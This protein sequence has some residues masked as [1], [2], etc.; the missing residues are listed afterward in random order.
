MRNIRKLA[1]WCVKRFGRTFGLDI[2]RVARR[3]APEAPHVLASSLVAPYAENTESGPANLELKL[4]RAARGGPF[5]CSDIVCT[6]QT[7]ARMVGS[8]R[9]IAELGGG[10]GLFAYEVATDP[11][12]VVVS[13]EHDEQAHRW[14]AMNR[15]RPNVRYVNGPINSSEGPFDLVVAIEVIEHIADYRAFLDTCVTLAERAIFTTPNKHARPR[16][17]W[18]GPPEYRYHVREWTAGELYWVMRSFYRS[19]RLFGILDP[20]TP[21]C[22]PIDITSEA[23]RIIAECESPYS[24]A[25]P[26]R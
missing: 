10:T 25:I 11:G 1:S 23:P 3:D 16:S 22:V 2:R 12:V 7:V 19:V 18:A 21:G 4:A 8:A 13:S 14:A 20:G 26:T 15:S 24:R 9:L 17:V 5:E 6:N